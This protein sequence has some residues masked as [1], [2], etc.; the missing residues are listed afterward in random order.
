MTPPTSAKVRE[1]LHNRE[2]ASEQVSERAKERKSERERERKRDDCI[3]QAYMLLPLLLL[4]RADPLKRCL[5][6]V[7]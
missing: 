3:T 6:F 1:A 4:L 2:L 7:V 5:Q